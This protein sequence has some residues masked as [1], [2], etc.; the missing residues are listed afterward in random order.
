MQ[1]RSS[2][3]GDRPHWA[4]YLRCPADG[5]KLTGPDDGGDTLEEWT[6]ELKCRGCGAEYPVDR[7]IV[8]FVDTTARTMLDHPAKRNEMIA[9]DR[10]ATSYEARFSS[11][12][13]AVEVSPCIR[14][15]ALDGSNAVAE[16]GCGTGRLTR[17]YLG[18][19]R[20]VVAVDFSMESLRQLRE[21]LQ[22][23]IR[24]RILLVHADITA[25]PLAKG[26]FDRVASFQVLEHLPTAELRLAAV[27][28]ARRLLAPE[29]RLAAS[30]YHW[31]ASKQR[32]ARRGQG[33]NTKK[34]GFHATV[35]PIY[36]VNFTVDE[37]RA[38]F[39]SADLRVD[40]VAGIQLQLP[41][42]S[43]LGP[44]VVPLNRAF[45]RTAFGLRHAHLL[46]VEA[47]P[48]TRN[49]RQFRRHYFAR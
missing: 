12:R 5:A 2:Q 18:H 31:S 43:L 49:P 48:R 8:C 27:R 29:G 10:A 46:L 14:A 28:E 30:V 23:A 4:T 37:A 1:N 35:P 39:E 41:L 11:I 15:L 22:P 20:Y 36:Y 26:A 32:E 24:N 19:A 3:Q 7:G 16:L 38:L 45:A 6:G 42:L 34:Q 40:T 47:S 13:N 9:R 44:F 17:R 33:D 25:L 21:E